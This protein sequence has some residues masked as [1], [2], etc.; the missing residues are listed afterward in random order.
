[1]AEQRPLSYVREGYLD[2]TR[3]EAVTIFP[4]AAE[5]E[6]EAGA[7]IRISDITEAKMMEKALIRSEK[8]ASVGVLSAGI[9]HEINNPNNFIMFNVPVLRRYLAAIMPIIKTHA[10]QNGDDLF[11]LS[12]EEFVRDLEELTESIEHGSQRIKGI[13]AELKDFSSLGDQEKTVW[14]NPEPAIRQ[15]IRLARVH[16]KGAVKQFTVDIP[17]VLP[18]TF[19]EMGRLEQVIVNILINATQ[20]VNKEDSQVSLRVWVV[21]SEPRQLAIAVSDNGYGMDEVQLTR[22]FDPFYTT[23]SPG[24]GT[25][26]G[27]Y[28]C[29][30]LIHKVGGRIEV[31]SQVGEGT[32]FTVFLSCI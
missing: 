32:T 18:D 25:G 12:P 6:E 11:G 17:E 2:S 22:I 29:H 28:I 3:T 19:F 8:L 13:V 9:A 30:N 31:E 27:L 23:K 4:I 26:L 21:A 15:A 10:G 5:R 1:V 14:G 16:L 7:V 20:A 24:I